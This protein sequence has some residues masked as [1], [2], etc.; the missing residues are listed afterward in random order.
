M[1]LTSEQRETVAEFYPLAISR[2]NALTRGYRNEIARD[3]AVDALIYA[4]RKYDASRGRSLRSYVTLAVNHAIY[5]EIARDAA[6]IRRVTTFALSAPSR[7]YWKRERHSEDSKWLERTSLVPRT[8][9]RESLRDALDI[10]I[11]QRMVAK[12]VLL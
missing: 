11:M 4:V 8:E 5:R 7:G 6:R 10:A 1:R 9:P 12:A 2:A 3:A